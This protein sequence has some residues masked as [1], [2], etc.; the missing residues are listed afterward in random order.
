MKRGKRIF[1]LG[2]YKLLW[3]MVAFFWMPVMKAASL[4]FK[5]GKI[6][7]KEGLMIHIP[8]NYRMDVYKTDPVESAILTNHF[9][10]PEPG[11]MLS[12]KD[13]SIAWK[14][15]EAGE[16]G[17]FR[18]KGLR[19]ASWMFMEIQSKTEK[20]VLLEGMGHNMVY[21]NGSPRM[22]NKYQN[23]ESFES[24]EPKFNFSLLPVKLRKGKNTLVFSVTRG[25]LKVLI[26]ALKNKVVLNVKDNTLPDFRLGETPDFPG[27]VVVINA[28]SK[29]VNTLTL[30]VSGNGLEQTI[31]KVPV[32][33]PFSLR[34]V[35]F[36]LK[37]PAPASRGEI[38]VTLQLKRGEEILD[39]K[40]VIIRKRNIYQ[41]YKRT[42][43]SSIDGSVQYYAVNPVKDKKIKGDPALVLSVHGASVEAI[44]QA[45]SYNNKSW[46]NIVSPTNRRPYGYD[47]EDWGRIDALE[48]LNQAKKSL[49]YDKERVYLTGHSMGGHGTWILGA[50]YPDLFAAIGPSAGWISWWSYR[51]RSRKEV[52]PMEKMLMRATLPAHTYALEK[53]YKQLGIYIIH[54]EEDD[55]VRISQSEQMVEHLKKFHK[56]F[57]F[58]RQPGAGHWWDVS[59][60]PGTD[61][62]DWPP[63]FDF[64]ARHVLPGKERIREINFR[65][66]NPGVA[67]DNNWLSIE[68][69]IHPLEISKVNIRF[70]PGRNLFEGST[71]NVERLSFDLVQVDKNRDLTVILD[72]SELKITGVTKE[73]KKVWL[74]RDG[75]VW[76]QAPESSKFLKGPHRYGTFKDAINHQ[77]VFVLGTKGNN[78][79]DQWASDKARYDAEISWYQGNGSI[80][81]IKDS[82]FDPVKYKDRNIILYGNES[83][84]YAWTSLLPDCPVH[85][86]KKMIKIGEKEI[87][88]SDLGIIFIY[89]RRDSDFA[90]VGV[91]AGTGLAGMQLTG[92]LPYL[93]PGTGFPDIMVIS[94]AYLNEGVKG[95]E[96]AGFFGNDWSVENE[97]I[98]FKN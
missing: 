19:G 13:T 18:D 34:K 69:Q 64:F 98:I 4:E 82:E 66:A 30:Q 29:P 1:S 60:E 3:I 88:G 15:L 68:A 91:V 51:I 85:V 79:A 27:A 77:V 41:P 46:A 52:L 67:S 36:Q 32:I 78:A 38:Q 56:D 80:E 65:T 73:T 74:S 90:S 86:T 53:N 48:V 75:E 47:W 9:K 89:P 92:S 16:D 87:K 5:D 37:G 59:E 96:A 43:I 12:F 10:A 26:H 28:D 11:E 71:E 23:K 55:N 70:D 21:V 62:V 17:W 8:R 84:N 76:K 42:F 49:P 50:T 97:E 14:K 95:V 58:H 25:R 45:S 39:S 93:Y 40:K 22:G 83:T 61:C 63:L 31:A 94:G 72:S 33:Q 57:V 35:G 24:W 2:K 20:T 54:G 6:M 7:L 81:I 44:N